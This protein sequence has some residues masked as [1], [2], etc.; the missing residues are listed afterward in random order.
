MWYVLGGMATGAVCI[1][2]VELFVGKL[3]QERKCK[4]MANAILFLLGFASVTGVY[5][6]AK[7]AKKSNGNKMERAI[8]NCKKLIK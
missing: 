2:A 7:T 5:E 8:N 3:A 1:V 4:K 6:V